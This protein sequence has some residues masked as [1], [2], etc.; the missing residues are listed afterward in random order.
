GRRKAARDG[1]CWGFPH[2]SSK[3]REG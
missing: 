2:F 3:G 1:R